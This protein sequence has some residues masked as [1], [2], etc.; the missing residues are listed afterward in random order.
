MKKKVKHWLLQFRKIS[1][2]LFEFNLEVLAKG[3]RQDKEIKAIEIG[4]K[5]EKFILAEYMIM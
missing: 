1:L 3:I 4:K 2:A 5:E